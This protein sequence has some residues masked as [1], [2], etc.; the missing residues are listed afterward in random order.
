MRKPGFPRGQFLGRQEPPRLEGGLVL[1]QQAL[2][3][4]GIVLQMAVELDLAG[5][6][7]PQ[8]STIF[9]P[10]FV[11]QEIGVASGHPTIVVTVER[12]CCLGKQRAQITSAT[13]W[14]HH[15][16]SQRFL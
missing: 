2:D 1:L 6:P 13:R 10:Q 9:L 3:Q 4:V 15:G 5:F 7:S 11:K 16:S 8:Q 12:P 14:T